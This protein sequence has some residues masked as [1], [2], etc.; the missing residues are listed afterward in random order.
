VALIV[1]GALALVEGFRSGMVLLYPF[2]ALTLFF[3]VQHTRAYFLP[4]PAR[5][6]RIAA[7]L[8]NVLGSCIAA[9]TAFLVV[10]SSGVLP[11]PPWVVWLAPTVVFTPMIVLWGR[12]W[13]RPAGRSA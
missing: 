7:H 9:W 3:G 10:T 6:A 8:G 13:A 1:G 11:V 4:P 12:A 5:P 2:G